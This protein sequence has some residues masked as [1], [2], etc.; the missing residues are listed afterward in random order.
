[1]DVN[2]FISDNSEGSGRYDRGNLSCLRGYVKHHEQGSF[3][4][5]VCFVFV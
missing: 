3:G 4:L 2:S 5:F 1:M